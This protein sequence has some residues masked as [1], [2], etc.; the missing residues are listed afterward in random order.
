MDKSGSTTQVI[1]FSEYVFENAV[2]GNLIFLYQNTNG[3]E[4]KKYH[5]DESYNLSEKIEN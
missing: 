5:F 2:T 3:L 1:T 4:S